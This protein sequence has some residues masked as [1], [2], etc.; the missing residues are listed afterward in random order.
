MRDYSYSS[1]H[2]PT[3]H[4]TLLQQDVW[5]LVKFASEYVHL[6]EL[7]MEIAALMVNNG[8]DALLFD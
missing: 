8:Q 2:H 3:P 5:L 1:Q 7:W 4:L 6:S